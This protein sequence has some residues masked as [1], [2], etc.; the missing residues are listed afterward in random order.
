MQRRIY[1]HFHCEPE[2]EFAETVKSEQHPEQYVP[3]M[4]AKS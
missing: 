1:C 3:M 4:R 2:S